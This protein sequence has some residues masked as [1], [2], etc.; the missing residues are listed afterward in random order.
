MMLGLVSFSPFVLGEKNLVFQGSNLFFVKY[1]IIIA[2]IN[3]GLFFIVTGILTYFGIFTGYNYS[4]MNKSEKAKCI[5]FGIIFNFPILIS[6]SF[7]IF[8]IPTTKLWF[9]I[10]WFLFLIYIII[11]LFFSIK[12]VKTG[13]FKS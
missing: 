8:T 11:K 5:L 9:E 6:F 7:V 10:C 1:S 4:Q 3:V 13:R 12:A 2:F